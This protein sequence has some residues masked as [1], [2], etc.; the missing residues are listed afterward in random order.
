MVISWLKKSQN[1]RFWAYMDQLLIG[2]VGGDIVL[3]GNTFKSFPQ[4]SMGYEGR[5]FY[6]HK[7]A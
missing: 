5:E 2:Y 4:L 6:S 7:L 1:I 3:P